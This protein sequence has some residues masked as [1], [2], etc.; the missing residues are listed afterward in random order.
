MSEPTK[1]TLFTT[2]SIYDKERLKYKIQTAI[3]EAENLMRDACGWDYEIP[4][5]VVK[6]ESTTKKVKALFSKKEHEV[7]DKNIVV[8]VFNK[9]LSEEEL[10]MWRMIKLGIFTQR[11]FQYGW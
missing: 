4:H 3:S 2:G 10:K 6:I 8:L 1:F 5:P 11:F 9:E 7:L